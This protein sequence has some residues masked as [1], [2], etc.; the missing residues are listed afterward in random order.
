MSENQIAINKQIVVIPPE[1]EIISEA[2][3]RLVDARLAIGVL[4][5]T[6]EEGRGKD[7]WKIPGTPSKSLLQR[8]ASRILQY[9]GLREEFEEVRFVENWDDDN[10]HFYY[11]VKARLFSINT[12]QEVGQSVGSCSTKEKKYAY[13]S[14]KQGGGKQ[15]P[16]H[17]FDMQHTVL[18]MAKKRALVSVARRVAGIEG[19]FTQDMEDFYDRGQQSEVSVFDP[20]TS[21]IT[22][23]AHARW[24][25]NSTGRSGQEI[26]D[27]LRV[28]RLRD[29]RGTILEAYN[30]V[31][32]SNDK[33]ALPDT[34]QESDIEDAEVI[35]AGELSDPQNVERLKGRIGGDISDDLLLSFLNIKSYNQWGGTLEEAYEFAMIEVE[36]G[37]GGETV[38]EE[39]AQTAPQTRKKKSSM[40]AVPE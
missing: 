34:S 33:P 26:V 22:N 7:F 19:E 16:Q 20:Y 1:R 18:L 39:P 40:D 13:K 31:L 23:E 15:P 28:D 37:S 3:S 2:R 27:I 8:G 25:V 29:W 36:R 17:A 21:R 35:E 32:L 11:N 12:G 14:Q 5:D 10:P 30:A 24:L 6:F 9:M 4:I 38:T